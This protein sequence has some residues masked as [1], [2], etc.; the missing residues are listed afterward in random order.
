MGHFIFNILGFNILTRIR[1]E[2]IFCYY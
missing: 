1:K 2:I